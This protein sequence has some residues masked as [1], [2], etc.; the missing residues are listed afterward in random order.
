MLNQTV[1][2]IIF[3]WWGENVAVRPGLKT[4]KLVP[5]IFLAPYC[6][7]NLTHSCEWD[8]RIVGRRQQTEDIITSAREQLDENNCGGVCLRVLS[9]KLSGLKA[10]LNPNWQLRL[11]SPEKKAVNATGRASC[12]QCD[13]KKLSGNSLEIKF[14]P[15]L[16][17]ATQIIDN[18]SREWRHQTRKLS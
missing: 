12:V 5:S 10:Q 14:F 11:S 17:N 2:C 1:P 13:T 15:K 6:S 18:F 9:I 3:L 8:G 16:T 7:W 4:A